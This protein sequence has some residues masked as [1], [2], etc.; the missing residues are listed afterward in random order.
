M[1]PYGRRM[2][3]VGLLSLCVFSGQFTWVKGMEEHQHTEAVEQSMLTPHMHQ[4]GAAHHGT[5]MKWTALRPPTDANRQRAAE[6]VSTLRRVLVKY[7]DVR[8]AEQNGFRP[9]HPEVPQQEYHFTNY[10]KGFKAA[11]RFDPEQPTSLLYKK[12]P[13]GYELVGAMYTAP[14]RASEDRL[15]QRVP[16][17]VTRW[18]AH[19]NLCFPPRGTDPKTVNWTRFGTRGAITTQEECNQAG[20][21]FWPQLFG[22][23]VH[24]YPFEDAPEKVWTHR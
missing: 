1:H 12:T 8:V 21:R 22:W 5:H 4:D 17:S 3:Y 6:I 14:K 15:N 24:V 20:G 18:H 9:F 13:S 2:L 10:W 7:K 11:F 16:L 23:M 19:V